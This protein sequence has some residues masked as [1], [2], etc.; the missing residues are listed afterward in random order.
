M[1]ECKRIEE[2]YFSGNTYLESTSK[3]KAK[4]HLKI[5]SNIEQYGNENIGPDLISKTNDKIYGIEHFEFD[6]TK[7]VRKGSK[8]RRQ[9]GK[10]DSVVN[11]QIKNKTEVHDMSVISLDQNIRTYI[12][13]YNKIYSYHYSRI[14]SYL[15][16]LNKDFPDIEKEIW[17]FIEDVT[18][19]GNHYLNED[20]IP[21][22]FHPMLS[23]ELIEL[24]KQSPQVKGIVFATN[25]FG[26]ENKLFVYLNNDSEIAKLEQICKS[27]AVKNLISQN[28]LCSTTMIK[29]NKSR[30]NE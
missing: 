2:K 14:S 27:K 3:L 7:N 9:I 25:S 17:F 30:E 16:N 10:I 6:S 28:V 24:F 1:N 11:E 20:G 26:N 12:D 29:I 5:L 23:Q 18:P 15:D 21:V 19:F 4:E 8:Y 22:L 13:N